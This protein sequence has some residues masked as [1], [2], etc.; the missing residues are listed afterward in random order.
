MYNLKHKI[1]VGYTKKM[2]LLIII[3]GCVNKSEHIIILLSF[4]ENPHDEIDKSSP[5]S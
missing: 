2:I 1:T 5:N 3:F 4:Q